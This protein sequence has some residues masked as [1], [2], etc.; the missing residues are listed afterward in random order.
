M[1]NEARRKVRIWLNNNC[2]FIEDYL[3][4]PFVDV[5]SRPYVELMSGQF[6]WPDIQHFELLSWEYPD[7]PIK[8]SVIK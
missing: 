7:D 2:S 8:S 1:P 4:N 6:K 3:V 5:Y